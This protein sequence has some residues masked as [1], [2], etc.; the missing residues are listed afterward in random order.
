MNDQWKIESP[1]TTAIT[2]PP[3]PVA[4]ADRNDHAGMV[5][6]CWS[7]APSTPALGRNEVHLWRANLDVP[8][9]DAYRDSLPASEVI[10]AD[11]FH[12]ERDRHRFTVSHGI[13]RMIL[14]RYLE[15][16]AGAI[17]FAHGAFGKPSL[18][19]NTTG[20]HFNLSHS[21]DIA[22]IAVARGSEVGVDVEQV[23]GDLPFDEI[24]EDYFEPEEIWGI[25]TL[26][27]SEKAWKFFDLWTTKEAR[28]KAS[29]AGIGHGLNPKPFEG[30]WLRKF[31][32]INAP[33][34]GIAKEYAGAIA[35]QGKDW[36]L[37]CWEWHK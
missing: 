37:A 12:A 3:V 33:T 31:S 27:D 6:L 21:G 32:I 26:R 16:D 11:A 23:R 25:R 1:M 8:S 34:F 7:P 35:M 20:I 5:A 24:A 29:G 10:R 9:A 30:S 17:R 28:L 15:M 14:A 18:A 36:R 2:R 22:L 4:C 13:L 19:D